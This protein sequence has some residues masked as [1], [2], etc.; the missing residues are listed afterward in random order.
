MRSRPSPAHGPAPIRLA[1]GRTRLALLLLAPLVGAPAATA[2]QFFDQ[3]R[4]DLTGQQNLTLGAG[5]R[6]YGMGGAFLARA[7]DATAAS[8]NPAG[9]S[10]LRL[11]EL[12]LVG[13]HN[14]FL[15]DGI[16]TDAFEGG[17]FDFAA[18]TWPVSIRDIRGAVQLSFQ[19]AIGFDGTRNLDVGAGIRL[20]GSSNGG[21]DVLAFGTGFRPTRRL[22]V[23]FT[24]NRWLNGYEQN[25]VRQ[26]PGHP[27]PL[28]EFNLD[29]RPRGWNFNFGVIWSASNSV[30]LGGVFKTPFRADVSLTKRRDDTWADATGLDDVTTNAASRDDVTIEFPASVGFG[31]SWRL[32]D[33]LTLSADFTQT[34][35]S[36]ANIQDYF[37]L[38][39]TPRREDPSEPLS[40]PLPIEFDELPYP[41]LTSEQVDAQ[42]I[43]VGAE[44]VVI[45]SPR[46]KIPV[47]AGYFNDRRITAY[48]DG[49]IPRYNGV[50]VGTGLILGSLLLDMAYLLEFGDDLVPIDVPSDDPDGPVTTVPVRYSLR[51]QRF[52]ASVIYRFSGHP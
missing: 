9:L 47:R 10:Y 42:Q 5:A 4:I 19:R 45:S 27:R 50:T 16:E 43:R 6:A 8:W 29:F 22:R 3:D 37:I 32:R 13:T 52:F 49:S 51:T 31:I 18:F 12:S 44:W 15:E 2:Q 7:D 33:T 34:R 30:N 39:F 48:P 24:A 14:S 26:V 1:R 17:S 40:P 35:W 25:L 21:F 28:R 38:P 36:T 41:T 11:P 23:G 46:I 20:D